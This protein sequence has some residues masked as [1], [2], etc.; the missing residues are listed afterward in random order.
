MSVQTSAKQVIFPYFVFCIVFIFAVVI[1]GY[2][3]QY[4]RLIYDQSPLAYYLWKI[5]V[6]LECGTSSRCNEL[7]IVNISRKFH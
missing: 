1:Q 6:P 2:I 4:G 5:N 7:F 3:T